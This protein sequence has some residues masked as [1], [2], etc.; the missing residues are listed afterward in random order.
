M[1]AHWGSA[2]N[3]FIQLNQNIR[4]KTIM[5]LFGNKINFLKISFK[6]QQNYLYTYP[7][8]KLYLI[9]SFYICILMYICSLGLI[10]SLFVHF[11]HILWL[12]KI[13]LE[14]KYM[15]KNEY[16]AWLYFP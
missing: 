4:P 8:H 14:L 5:E 6:K 13:I 15:Y 12:C 1:L 9:T 2:V 3:S 11:L 16:Y 10:I 7:A